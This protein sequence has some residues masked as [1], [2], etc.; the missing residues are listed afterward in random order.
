MRS[1]REI[2][3]A[4]I[5]VCFRSSEMESRSPEGSADTERLLP[6]FLRGITRH[7]PRQ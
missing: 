6:F 4:G 7:P 5:G 2:Q 3:A 1:K